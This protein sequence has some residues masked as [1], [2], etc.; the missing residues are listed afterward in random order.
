MWDVPMP[1]Q[2][3]KA[4]ASVALAS[5]MTLGQVAASGIIIGAIL[6][7][8]SLEWRGYSGIQLVNDVIPDG[9]VA[10]IQVQVGLD[11]AMKGAAMITGTNQWAV[12][13]DGYAAGL[14]CFV[15]VAVV[16][17]RERRAVPVALIVFIVGIIMAGVTM[18]QSG[19]HFGVAPGFPA[20]D[21]SRYIAPADW[22]YATVF[23][24]LPQLPLTTLNSIVA[25]TALTAKLW[26][27]K[28]IRNAPVTRSVGLMNIVLCWFGGMPM[29][30][31]AGGLSG[32]YMFGARGGCS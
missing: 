5:K 16:I 20:F 17:F 13:A 28:R 19:A 32:Q 31:G 15:F 10:G 24:A 2:P 8:L 14:L 25:V 22:G 4:I 29:C 21:V 3:M 18:A 27:E 23:A 9:V 12:K 7:L 30:H 26:P 6:L 1:V 11:L